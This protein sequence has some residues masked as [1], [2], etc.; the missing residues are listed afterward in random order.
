MTKSR[1]NDSEQSNSGNQKTNGR[2]DSVQSRSRNEQENERV[3]GK[4]GSRQSLKHIDGD[5]PLCMRK[6]DKRC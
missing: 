5:V 3:K 4:G 6:K 2:D 1:R